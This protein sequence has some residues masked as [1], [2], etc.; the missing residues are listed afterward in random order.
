MDVS[1]PPLD[2]DAMTAAYGALTRGHGRLD[3][4]AVWLAGVQGTATP[5][6][7]ERRRLVVLND[8]DAEADV[9][10]PRDAAYADG[11]AL[12][13]REVDAGAV[14]FVAVGR[15]T[16]A[17]RALVAALTGAEPV[18]VAAP[19]PAWA[20][21]VASVRDTL[22]AHRDA[23]PLDL[24]AT[25]GLAGAAGFLVGAAR[26]RTPVV[27]DGLTPAAAALAATHAAPAAVAY[28]VAGHLTPEPAHAKALEHLALEPLLDLGIAADGG[29]LL[30][31]PL[32]DAAADLL[33]PE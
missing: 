17:A 28:F 8:A 15:P 1:I 24:A 29:A 30:A 25:L 4:L 6:R 10:V 2:D 5:H 31:L 32:L 21:D 18:E 9:T 11:L 14:V 16:V 7:L 12:A 13:A 3:G 20:A 33:A 19:G 22:R 23:D 27:L 26:R